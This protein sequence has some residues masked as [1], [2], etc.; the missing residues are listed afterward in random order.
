MDGLK[1]LFCYQFDRTA[2]DWSLPEVTLE[3][4]VKGNLQ[5]GT[6]WKIN[7]EANGRLNDSVLGSTLIDLSTG[8]L[9][10]GLMCL[11]MAQHSGSL[12]M[13]RSASFTI[14]KGG[15]LSWM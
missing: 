5:S 8:S 6:R 14:Q 1:R 12:L 9:T 11:E 4:L 15:M 10:T 13:E 7:R 3:R 2:P